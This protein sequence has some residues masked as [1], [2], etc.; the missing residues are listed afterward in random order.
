MDRFTRQRTGNV[1]TDLACKG[2]ERQ[3]NPKAQEIKTKFENCQVCGK[4]YKKGRGLSISS[5]PPES[6]HSGSTKGNNLPRHSSTPAQTE[7]MKESEKLEVSSQQKK[8]SVQSTAKEK[9]REEDILVIDNEIEKSIKKTVLTL[10]QCI[11]KKLKGIRNESEGKIKHR[12]EKFVILQNSSGHSKKETLSKKEKKKHRK[13]EPAE[14]MN[15]K[16]FVNYKTGSTQ[17]QG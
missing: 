9:I 16:K 15:I 13:A 3:N 17:K 10:P 1:K 11:E 6:H 8:T 4:S 5:S 12:E 7:S 14:Y 2:R